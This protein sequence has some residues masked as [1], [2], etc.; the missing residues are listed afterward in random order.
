MDIHEKLQELFSLEGKVILVTGAAGGI[1]SEVSKGMAQ[2]GGTMALC[3]FNK[4]G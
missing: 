3:D 2:V 4:D 1:F